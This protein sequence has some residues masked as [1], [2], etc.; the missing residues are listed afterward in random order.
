MQA[1]ISIAQINDYFAVVV[2]ITPP[3]PLLAKEAHREGSDD[4]E[5]R[6]SRDNHV[7]NWSRLPGHIRLVIVEWEKVDS[8]YSARQPAR[9]RRNVKPSARGCRQR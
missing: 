3:R 6:R 4:D 2:T 1:E 7:Q 5:V 9:G 8:K